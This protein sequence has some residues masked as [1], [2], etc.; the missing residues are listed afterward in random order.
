M[1]NIQ[2][3]DCCSSRNNVDIDSDDDEDKYKKNKNIKL[4][5]NN[6]KTAPGPPI[7]I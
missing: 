2:F 7:F 1:G 5:E 6:Y 3:K 4:V